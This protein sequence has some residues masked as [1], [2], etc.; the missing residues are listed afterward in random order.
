MYMKVE[1]YKKAENY[2]SQ[3]DY[4]LKLVQD[5]IMEEQSASEEAKLQQLKVIDEILARIYS[6]FCLLRMQ[7]KNIIS[8]REYM[9]L[10]LEK[11]ENVANRN[12]IP[13]LFTIKY[14]CL[15]HL[16]CR[17]ENQSINTALTYLQKFPE[18]DET[19]GHRMWFMK[20]LADRGHNEYKEELKQKI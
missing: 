1:G 9:A 13:Y 2:L 17:E 3:A 19:V 12:S 20:F 10:S 14:K 4:T 6:S 18:V 11:W 16:A 5:Q 7:Q 15:L 8:A